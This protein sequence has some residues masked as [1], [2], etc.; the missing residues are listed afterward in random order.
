MT[1]PKIQCSPSK[2]QQV[3][4]N[5]LKNGAEAMAEKEYAQ[6]QSTFNV[7]N[8]QKDNWCIIEIGDNG[9]GMDKDTQKRI[10]EPFYTTKDP[11]VGTGL[12]LSISYF[13]ITENHKGDMW[14]EILSGRR[15]KVFLSAC[16]S[17]NFPLTHSPL[18]NKFPPL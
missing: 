8:Y 17:N 6:G 15:H 3:L 9:P 4:L 7:K 18:I 13:I 14:V 16:Q 1:L 10:F 12:G 2:I 11:G 5:I